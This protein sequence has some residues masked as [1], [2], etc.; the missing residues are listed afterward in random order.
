MNEMISPNDSRRHWRS[1]VAEYAGLTAA[2]MLL[3]LTFSLLSPHFFAFSTAITIANNNADL[4]VIAVGMTLVLVLGE[5]D[6]SVGSVLALGGALLGVVIV[7]I[8]WPLAGIWQWLLILPLAVIACLAVGALCGAVSGSLNALLGIPSFIITLGMLEMARGSAYLVTGSETK[9]IGAIVE[10]IG[11]PLPV[12]GLSPA[13]L[14]AVAVVILGQLTLTR[15]VFGRY[16]VAIGTNQQAVRLAGI[17]PRPTRIAVFALSGLLAALAGVFQTARLSTAD[18]NTA[19]GMELSAIAAVVIGGTSL[20]GG[21][22]NVI[23]SLLGVLI[24]AVLQNGLAQVGAGEPT[25]RIITGA[26]IVLAVTIDAVRHR[27]D[28]QYFKRLVRQLLGRRT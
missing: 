2:L 27:F 20:M 15:T 17:D 10:P 23:N 4:M 18:P 12:L 13:F 3:T 26:V 16:C 22:G 19:V 5:I 11:A 14:L 21:R 24:I 9:Y 1:L 8:P 7:D 28:A 6:L 25:K